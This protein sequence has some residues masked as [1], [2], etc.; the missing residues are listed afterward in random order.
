M[1]ELADQVGKLL[2][3]IGIDRRGIIAQALV[4][5]DGTIEDFGIGQAGTQAGEPNGVGQPRRAGT[6]MAGG[7]FFQFVQRCADRV[8]A[9]F[10]GPAF[11]LAAGFPEPAGKKRGERKTDGGDGQ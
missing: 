8:L 10:L 1:D 11:E 4:E 5:G 2:F 6:E 7:G 9:C 3:Q